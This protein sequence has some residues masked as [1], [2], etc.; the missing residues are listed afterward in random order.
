M[1]TFWLVSFGAAFSSMLSYGFAF[2]LPAFFG[3][4]LKLPLADLS[5]WWGSVVLVG[6]IAGVW[7][8]GWL[9]DRLGGARKAWYAWVPAA[10]FALAIPFMLL[11]VTGA[12]PGL[13]FLLFLVPQALSVAWLGPVIAAVQHLVPPAMRATASALFL[14]VNNLLGIGMGTLMFGAMSDILTPRYGDDALKMSILI[15]T[16]VFYPLASLCFLAAGRRLD[17]VWVR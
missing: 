15:G 4:S 9:G 14:F 7:L 1:P 16:A 11:A 12:R 6:G 10:A 5:L 3:C 8:G 2:W 17:R 13:S